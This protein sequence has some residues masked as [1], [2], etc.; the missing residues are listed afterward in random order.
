MGSL[1]TLVW[2]TMGLKRGK[3]E[4]EAP[5]FPFEVGDRLRLKP[6]GKFEFTLSKVTLMPNGDWDI[7]W[8]GCKLDV[9]DLEKVCLHQYRV[10]GD[11]SYYQ[12]IFCPDCEAK[13]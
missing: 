7:G 11:F 6:G 9:E 12:T 5:R 1:E 13:I 8:D 4:P 3:G 10:E 2:W